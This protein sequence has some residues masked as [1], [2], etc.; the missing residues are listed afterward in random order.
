MMRLPERGEPG[1][2]PQSRTR[3]VTDGAGG[4]V[5]VELCIVV[6]A[7]NEEKNLPLLVEELV[8][9]LGPVGIGFEVLF[10][11]DGSRDETAAVLRRLTAS[12]E[13]IR[14]VLLSR[15]F[16]HQAAVS[17]GLQHARGSAIAVMD[18]D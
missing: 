15:N 8:R 14:A 3:R 13:N 12:H 16:G 6:P 9:A 4:V 18:A 17:I 7:Y 1:P 2:V 11:D 10:V 5:A